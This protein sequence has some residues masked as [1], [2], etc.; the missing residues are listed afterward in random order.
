MA[1]ESDINRFKLVPVRNSVFNRKNE[2]NPKPVWTGYKNAIFADLGR[3]RF[4]TLCS[5][6]RLKR[7]FKLTLHI[8]HVGFWQVRQKIFNRSPFR[9][10][11][12]EFVF[13]FITR[14]ERTVQSEL[15]CFVRESVPSCSSQIGTCCVG[16]GVGSRTGSGSGSGAFGF[17]NCAWNVRYKNVRIISKAPIFREKNQ[18]PF[19]FDLDSGRTFVLDWTKVV[20]WL[21][22]IIV[23]YITSNI[24]TQFWDFS[25]K[26]KSTFTPL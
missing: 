8:E 24:F 7:I 20:W 26:P 15:N 1:L 16:G 25:T 14:T 5:R 4:W 2:L 22:E 6:W 10:F 19:N 13:A 11:P 23:W 12:N 21:N 9:I 18:G 17:D 3:G